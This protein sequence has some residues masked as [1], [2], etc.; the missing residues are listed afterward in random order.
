MKTLIF[1]LDGV[2]VDF[3]NLHERAFISAWNE[4]CPDHLI[5][6]S[7]HLLY[8]EARSTRAKIDICWKIFSM[9][10]STD[11][12]NAIFEKKQALT[13]RLLDSEPV[14]TATTRA[15]CWAA[16]RGHKMALCSNSIRS[17]VMKSLRRLACTDLFNVILSNEDVDKPKPSPEIYLKA[18]AQLG[19]CAD[20]CIIFEDSAVGRQAA[21]AALNGTRGKLVPIV[22]AQDMTYQLLQTVIEDTYPPIPEQINLVIPMAGLGSRFQKEGYKIP[23]PFLPVF[24]KP[25]YRWVIDNM[26]P[27]AP[28]WRE[29]VQVHVLVREEQASLFESDKGIQIHTVPKLTE[30]AAC[31]VLTI[32]ELI[33]TN[34][35]L[36][37]ANSDQFLEWDADNFYLSLLHPGFDGVISTFVQPDLNDI[38]WSYARLDADRCVVEVAEKKVISDLATTGIYGWSCGSDFIAAADT[39]IAADIRVNNEFYVCPVYNSMP[40][41]SRI[42]IHNCKKMWGLGV[43]TDYEHFLQSWKTT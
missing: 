35:P 1:D 41:S 9:E 4:C 27:R 40:Q 39:M 24:G 12:Q 29:R 20:D 43:P 25:M 42:R 5:D 34:A 13:D 19:V 31:T 18:M 21:A 11:I 36:I 37:I 33:N 15:L 38:R 17:T 8:L 32:R 2:L 3:A 30:G 28:E 26:L 10:D 7:F 6:H 22:N 14:Y 16:A 23:K